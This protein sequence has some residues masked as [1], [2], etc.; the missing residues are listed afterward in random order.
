[1][2]TDLLRAVE[3]ETAI[4]AHRRLDEVGPARLRNLALQKG[5]PVLSIDTKNKELVGNFA[6]DG[7]TQT[8]P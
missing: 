1:M 5:C 3:P 2:K 4:F 8:L 7:A 6:H